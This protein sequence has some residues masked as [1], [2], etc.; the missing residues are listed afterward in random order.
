MSNVYRWLSSGI[1][2]KMYDPLLHRLVHKLMKK[3][4]FQLLLHFKQLGCEVVYG[5]F[6]KLYLH[7]K[8][9][10]F[11]EAKNFIDFVTK[12]IREN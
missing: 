2:S 6:N 10:D 8:K 7:T 1:A 4:F 9:R 11:E 12:T 5:S 3:N